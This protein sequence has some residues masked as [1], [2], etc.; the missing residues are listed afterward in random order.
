MR[1]ELSVAEAAVAEEQVRLAVVLDR[2]A[3]HQFCRRDLALFVQPVP[4]FPELRSVRGCASSGW[5]APSS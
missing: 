5:D 1:T 4:L 3:V 2:L